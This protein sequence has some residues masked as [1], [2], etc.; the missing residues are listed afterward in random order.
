MTA[1][2]QDAIVQMFA[3]REQQR[4]ER[5]A[6]LWGALT[7]RERELVREVAAMTNVRA[8]M[9]AGQHTQAPPPDAAVVYDTLA[10]CLSM[11]DLYP[12]LARIARIA[13]RRALR[14]RE[15]S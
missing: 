3:A 12:T 11:P 14:A 10:A 1:D 8:T 6:R 15:A 4:R 13:E 2:V 9:R 5:I 7:K